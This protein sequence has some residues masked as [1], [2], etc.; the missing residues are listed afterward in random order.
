MNV[1]KKLIAKIKYRKFC[2]LNG[3]FCPDCIYHDFLWEGSIFRGNRCRHP[4]ARL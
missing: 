3:Y 4:Y 2:K 1:I